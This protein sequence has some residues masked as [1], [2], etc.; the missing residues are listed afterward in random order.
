MT[1]SFAPLLKPLLESTLDSLKIESIDKD[2]VEI[3]YPGRHG[4]SQYY[5]RG[6][7][8]TLTSKRS[9]IEN[10][11]LLS[12]IENIA[13]DNNFEV[14]LSMS[15]FSHDNESSTL[16]TIRVEKTVG[17]VNEKDIDTYRK[18]VE[19]NYLKEWNSNTSFIKKLKYILGRG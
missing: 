17:C 14:V 2:K 8:I 4:N 12:A 9:D 10:I 3:Y 7:K 13:K 11:D 1:K 19:T 18:E 16:I 15:K 5:D 6:E